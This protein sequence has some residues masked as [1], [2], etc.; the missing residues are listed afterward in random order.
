MACARAG[1]AIA[2]GRVRMFLSPRRPEGANLDA[3][4]ANSVSELLKHLPVGGA[5]GSNTTVTATAAR[6][7][8]AFDRHG[9]LAHRLGG[10]DL[11][12]CKPTAEEAVVEQLVAEEVARNRAAHAR[13]V[14]KRLAAKVNCSVNADELRAQEM[15]IPVH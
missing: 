1:Y 7:K 9:K 10:P 2:H 15:I 13:R 5:G 3:A 12:A 6:L 11:P 4:S 8:T 14:G